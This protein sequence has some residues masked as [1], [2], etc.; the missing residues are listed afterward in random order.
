MEKLA[1]SIGIAGSVRLSLSASYWGSDRLLIE[2]EGVQV[3]E[4]TDRHGGHDI[5][6]AAARLKG[7]PVALPWSR[8]NGQLDSQGRSLSL[9]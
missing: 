9:P 5:D 1:K 2:D 3:A 8:N 7:A 4:G 6:L